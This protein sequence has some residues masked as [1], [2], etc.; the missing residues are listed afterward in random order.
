MIV[1]GVVTTPLLSAPYCSVRG[2]SDQSEGRGYWMAPDGK[3]YPPEMHRNFLP[4]T[5]TPPPATRSTGICRYCHGDVPADAQKC[6]HCGE[7]LAERLKRQRVREVVDQKDMLSPAG[8]VLFNLVLSLTVFAAVFYRTAPDAAA[9]GAFA[10]LS[11]L[12]IGIIIWY[13]RS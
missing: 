12:I 2:V 10:L 7:F 9:G 13:L 8:M 5:P 4:T 6:M 3:W 1:A 11:F